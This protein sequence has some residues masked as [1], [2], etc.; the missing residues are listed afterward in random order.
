[1][2]GEAAFTQ[3]ALA[4]SQAARR[5]DN[6]DVA[7]VERFQA[8]DESA[9]EGIFG[10][11]Q[12][13]IFGLCLTVTGDYERA[14]DAAQETFLRA[15]ANL[16]KVRSPERLGHWLRKIA[17]NVCRAEMKASARRP[18]LTAEGDMEGF[19]LGVCEGTTQDSMRDALVQQV[20]GSLKP[21]YRLVLVLREVQGLSYQEI[22][23]VTGCSLTLVKVRLHRARKAFAQRFLAD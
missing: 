7:L 16:A 23:E 9:F 10:R 17:V 2:S 22:A 3:L 1:M 13:N 11:Y 4:S 6:A 5:V 15:Y 8:G 19:G 20:L 21:E 18:V 12:D 14:Q